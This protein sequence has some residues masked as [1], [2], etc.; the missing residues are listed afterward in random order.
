[1]REASRV[2][3]AAC[4]KGDSA[5]ARAAL[6]A[7]GQALLA[8]RR[9]V[10]LSELV[11]LLG[12]ELAQEVAVLNQSRYAGQAAVWQGGSL[13]TL[14]ERLQQ[15]ETGATRSAVNDDLLPLNP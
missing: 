6:L 5:A 12:D 9:V 8:P 13:W 10:N 7:W 14:C 11:D 15:Q 2:L 3:R 4:E 1:L